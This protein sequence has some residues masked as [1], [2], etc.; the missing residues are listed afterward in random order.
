MSIPNYEK[1]EFRIC[2]IG[3]D[4][5]GKKTLVN[6]FKN[7]KATDT[8]EFPNPPKIKIRNKSEKEKEKDHLKPCEYGSEKIEVPKIRTKIENLTN[9]T[10]VIRIDKNQIEFNFF[11]VPAAEKVGFSDVLNDEDETEKL[12]KM[13]FNN[14][15]NYFKELLAKPGK[16]NLPIRYVFLFMF[17][18]TINETYEKAKVYIHEINNITNFQKNLLRNYFPVLIGNKIDLKYPYEVIDRN[19]LEVYINEN[20]LKFYEASGKLYFNFENFFKKIFFDLFESEY[21]AFSTELFKQRFSEVVGHVKTIPSSNYENFKDNGVPEPSR[22][23][24]NV[25]DLNKNPG[26]IN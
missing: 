13:K 23:F 26:K 12:H 22:Y 14:V 19:A 21:F 6:R 8:I 3:E 20:N 4:F 25:Y 18:I 7:M 2:L 5:V 24:S 15:R 16:E 10:K 1:L 9:F 11:I 17:D